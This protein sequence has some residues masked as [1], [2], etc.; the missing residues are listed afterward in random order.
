METPIDT[1]TRAHARTRARTH[2]H[3]HTSWITTIRTS[4]QFDKGTVKNSESNAYNGHQNE[5]IIAQP[6]W[7]AI[8][9]FTFNIH[10]GTPTVKFRREGQKFL[11]PH[12]TAIC[13]G[14]CVSKTYLCSKSILINTDNPL[15]TDTRY[16][17]QIRYD[18]NLTVTKPSLK[19]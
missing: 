7:P 11:V 19:R 14:I 1:H 12:V 4:D 9:T 2:T 5:L 18:D 6:N 10:K 17:D 13:S 15:Y 16:T 8:F 3:T